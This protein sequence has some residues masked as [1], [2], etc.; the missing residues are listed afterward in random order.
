MRNGFAQDGEGAR[1]LLLLLLEGI[2]RRYG[3]IV[4]EI[5]RLQQIL[6]GLKAS[7]DDENSEVVTAQLKL[8]PF[9]PVVL[10][11]RCAGATYNSLPAQLRG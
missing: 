5:S 10:L 6:V 11:Q 9:K 3:V 1:E 2:A 8:R 4:Q 7:S